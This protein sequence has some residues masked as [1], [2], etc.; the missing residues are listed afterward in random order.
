MSSIINVLKNFRDR[1]RAG[2][3][4]KAQNFL[5]FAALVLLVVIAIGIRLSPL[6]VNN[7]MIKAF[8]P[9]IQ[10]YNAN[11][12]SNHTLYQYFNW[13][14]F[15]SWFPEGFYRGSLR[16]GLTFAVVV[17]Y[18]FFTMLGIPITLYDVC[19]FFPA[20]MGGASV[21]VSYFLGKEVLDK[22]CGLFFAFFMAFN[23]GF[24]QRTAAGFFD[25]ETVG[26]FG[27][28][29]TLLFFLKAMRTGRITH[30]IL[31]GVFLGFL[32]LSW[33]GY[34]YIFYLLPLIVGV[35]I[36]TGK[37]NPKVLAAYA[38]VIG[39]GLLIFS[40][41][42]EFNYDELFSSLDIGGV[43]FFTIIL[44]VFHLIYSKKDSSPKFYKNILNTI[45]WGIIPIAVIVGVIIWI[46]PDLIP[47]GLGA[48]LN[49]ILS[50]LL[51]EN[52]SLVAS[53]AEHSPSSWSVFYYNTLVP[54]MLLP[55]GVFFAFKRSSY[56]D[57]FLIIF[58]LTLFYFTGSMIRIILL[59]APAASL[60][61]AYGLSNILKIFGSFFGE[62]KNISRKRKRQIK[63]TVG[64]FEIG[65][66]YFI[67]GIMCF[68]QVTHATQVATTDLSYS[69]IAPGGQFHDWE[70]ALTWTRTN[71]AGTTVIVSWWDYGYWLTAIGN[72]T[73]VN[74]NAT[75]NSTRIGLVGMAF[76]QTNELYSA[77]IFRK[78]HADYVLVYF[79]FL[80]SPLGGDEGKWPW[81]LR[82]C[83]D[84]YE[85]YK[86]MGLQKDNWAENS[87]FD[88]NQYWNATSQT[89]ES[90]WFQSQIV[91][92]MFYGLPTDPITTSQPQNFVQY[93]Q[94]QITTQRKDSY[95]NYWATDI[96]YN[97]A[98]DFKVFQSVFNST[99]GMVKIYQMDYTALDSSFSIKDPQV[100]DTDF[101]TF[102]IVNTGLKNLTIS[103]V[104][105]NGISYNYYLGKSTSDKI[106]ASDEDLVWV[107]MKSGGGDFHAN[108]VANITVQAEAPALEGKTYTFTNSTSNIFVEKAP[109]G[110]IKINRANS[111]VE[112]VNN[113]SS[114]IHLE[115]ENTGA[116]DVVL[117]KVYHGSEENE[118]SN[119]ILESGSSILEPGQKATFL[120]KNSAIPFYPLGTEQ[121]IGVSTPNDI[122][123]EILMTSNYDN[124]KISI[125]PQD[126]IISPELSIAQDNATLRDQIPISLS[127][128]HSYT[129]DNGTSIL[130]IKLKNTGDVILG[131]D[132]IYLKGTGSWIS[133]SFTPFNLLPGQEKQVT[134]RVSDYFNLNVNDEVGVK[135]TADFDG[136]TKASD[137][138]YLQT[139]NDGPDIQILE[140]VKGT[141]ISSI[142]ANETGRILVK[143]TGDKPI[144]LSEIILNGTS[145]L[146][147]DNDTTFKFG[148]KVL[149]IQDCALISFNISDFN[150]NATNTL[151]VQVLTN[152]TATDMVDLTAT[153]NSELY[154]IEINN[155]GTIAKDS[156]N[157]NIEIKNIGKLN[158]TLDAVYINGTLIS[159]PEIGDVIAS[160]GSLVLTISM[161][162]LESKIGTVN[163]GNQLEMLVRTKEGAEDT[164]L[165]TV[166]F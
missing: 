146:S 82:I 119:A 154:N 72:M 134:V 54:L 147:I 5:L 142:S 16:P 8:D 43:F 35:I 98:Y 152:T 156:G 70:E 32:S 42:V 53:V 106:N 145:V 137:I 136:S 7:Y 41:Y 81:M 86:Q 123:D 36:V 22:K 100:Y 25:N 21:L 74:D 4:V 139:I 94:Y 110:Q 115:V 104:K 1:I 87:V 48:R 18:K 83:N 51:R 158:V 62:R 10:Y 112:Q 95:G 38:G 101:A 27:T 127:D 126:R 93:Y 92:L 75:I 144:E 160:D 14:D 9:W 148:G 143:N 78:L 159:F 151:S 24:M 12:L 138:A 153:V 69:Q 47:L 128:T 61:G 164:H 118:F 49:S 58:L 3:T 80:Y 76:T 131:L 130:S 6:A 89:P 37:Y 40:L 155:P 79:G 23:V 57:I 102:K 88:E 116:T 33:G 163:I 30:S 166:V 125:L 103:D 99:L 34:N 11:Y 84:H 113:T 140:N 28:L 56:I 108:D 63:T 67:V 149:G 55:L 65:L 129:Y 91:R 71:L 52:L 31:G 39:T 157:V 90:M 120:I 2:L 109:E 124:F 68:V 73:T 77:E 17:I 161:A 15:K 117:D 29:M 122:K 162:T 60:V 111:W 26:V 150:L 97:G 44:V 66:V 141:T 20:F 133:T 59:F 105:V 96:P 114:N 107:D 50:P 85:A 135:I 13:R 132:S 45:K 165:E 121:L 46:N 64:N 19:F